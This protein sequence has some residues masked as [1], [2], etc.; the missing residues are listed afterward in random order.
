MCVFAPKFDPMETVGNSKLA[1]IR[2][3]IQFGLSFRQHNHGSIVAPLDEASL[4]IMP[5]DGVYGLRKSVSA[6]DDK[7]Y[8]F[9]KVF[10]QSATQ[11]DIYDHVADHVLET[12]R[13]YNTTIFAYGATGVSGNVI[14]LTIDLYYFK[15]TLFRI[16]V[17]E[18]VYY[19]RE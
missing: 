17:R 7:I 18:V 4:K 3:Y 8:T 11:E 13:G 5:P 6:M 2:L 1:L 12:I 9:D 10:T 14:S 19:D 16:A 15:Y